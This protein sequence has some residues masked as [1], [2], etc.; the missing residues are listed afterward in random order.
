M[1]SIS[2]FLDGAAKAIDQNENN[3][4]PATDWISKLEREYDTL[5]LPRL[6]CNIQTALVGGEKL[7]SRKDNVAVIDS[8][9]L[10]CHEL[11]SKQQPCHKIWK[12]VATLLAKKHPQEYGNIQYVMDGDRR[13][14]LVGKRG[15]GGRYGSKHLHTRLANQYYDTMKR[16][17]VKANSEAASSAAGEDEPDEVAVKKGRKKRKPG[18]DTFQMS[19]TISKIKRRA[20]EKIMTSLEETNDFETLERGF[21]KCQDLIQFEFFNNSASSAVA[22]YP[23]FFSDEKFFKSHYHS[24][25]DDEGQV[26]DNPQQCLL[27]ELEILQEIVFDLVPNSKVQELKQLRDLAPSKPQ[28]MNSL[29]EVLADCWDEDFSF[30]VLKTD[31]PNQCRKDCAEPH[32]VVLCED[33]NNVSIFADGTAIF[34]NL[35]YATALG[36]MIGLHFL[37]NLEYK[38]ECSNIKNFIQREIFSIAR[39]QF[40]RNKRKTLD[41]VSKYQL[42][43]GNFLQKRRKEVIHRVASLDA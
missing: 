42:L 16:K 24:I 39:M 7:F 6:A 12:R 2:N 30:A 20:L 31:I 19:P 37:C 3:V 4:E 34:Q 23:K 29:L 33:Y 17:R 21:A 27:L 22:L 13:I 32:C 1:F 40:P 25:S 41:S 26:L 15:E 11:N 10:L 8:M 9:V 35:D 14:E 28:Y 5:F 36:F 18:L 43:K 38:E